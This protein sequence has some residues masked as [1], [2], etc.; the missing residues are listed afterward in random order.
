MKNLI[1]AIFASLLFLG[2][3]MINPGYISSKPDIEKLMLH[4][5]TVQYAKRVLGEPAYYS[6]NMRQGEI[7]H[8]YYYKTPN[9]SVSIKK[10]IKGNYSSG[11]SGCGEIYMVFVHDKNSQDYILRGI[12]VE[13]E[14]VEALLEEANKYICSKKYSNAYPLL[15]KASKMHLLPAQHTL[16]LLYINGDGV[17]KDYDKARYW[18]ERAA[19]ANHPMSLY[20]LGVMYRNGEGVDRDIQKAIVLYEKS[21][22]LR[23]QNAM[24]ELVKIY[25]DLGMQEREEHWAK[26]LESFSR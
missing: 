9:A 17:Q 3:S 8:K 20:D 7:V 16:G 10:M 13:D 4:Q 23:N 18:L 26:R 6:L 22:T 25:K 1:I 19:L 12:S 14:H 15:T 2:C 24:R 5:S 11:C 21:A